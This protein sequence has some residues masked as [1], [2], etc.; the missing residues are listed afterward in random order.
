MNEAQL[1]ANKKWCEKNRVRSNYLKNRSACKSFIKKASY[2]DLIEIKNLVDENINTR[3]NF[4]DD[5]EILEE[6]CK[7]YISDRMKSDPWDK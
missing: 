4:K 3:F 6:I 7:D 5:N 2:E 1:K